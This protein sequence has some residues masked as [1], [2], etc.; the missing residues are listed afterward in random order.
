MKQNNHFPRVATD[1]IIMQLVWALGFFGIMLIIHFFKIGRLT[2]FQG[3]EVDTFYNS[4]FIPANIFMLV[5]GIICVYFLPHYV[6]NGVTRKDYFKGA[7]LAT[8][9]LSITLPVLAFIISSITKAIVNIN[10]READINSVIQEI[11]GGIGDIIG[12]IV[13]LII[14]SPHV[15]LS[16]N[17]LLAIAIFSLNLFMYYLLGWLISASFYKYDFIIGIVSIVASI[18]ILM[19]GDTMIRIALDFPIFDRFSALASLP[20]SIPL[21]VILLVILLT[22]W[23]IRQLTKRVTIKM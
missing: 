14:L 8:I 11:D 9:G 21:F 22:V 23:I 7:L 17:W 18:L 3:D 10:Y 4:V 12:D 1:M 13:Q 6:E 5:I 15:D 20:S 2:F 16:N 19:F